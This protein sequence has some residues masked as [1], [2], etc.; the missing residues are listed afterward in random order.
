MRSTWPLM[1]CR[2]GGHGGE[3]PECRKVR[4]RCGNARQPGGRQGSAPHSM[5]A[6]HPTRRFSHRA[7]AAARRFDRV[8]VPLPMTLQPAQ[9]STRKQA[10]G[11]RSCGCARREQFPL[12][13]LRSGSHPFRHDV[14]GLRVSHATAEPNR[15]RL[16]NR[17]APISPTKALSRTMTR[18][19][20]STTLGAPLTAMPSNAL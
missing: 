6:P 7:V 5:V 20:E 17:P 12:E 15:L 10:E 18:P 11:E 3:L 8:H 19:R 1:R 4:E 13:G 2:R 9:C 16:R 14:V